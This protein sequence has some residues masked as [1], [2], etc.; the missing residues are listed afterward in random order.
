MIF[1]KM[2]QFLVDDKNQSE[3]FVMINLLEKIDKK[4]LYAK[5]SKLIH[6]LLDDLSLKDEK[7]QEKLTKVKEKL[8]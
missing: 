5:T 8:K 2:K 6:Q 1:S 4:S 3:L 7:Q